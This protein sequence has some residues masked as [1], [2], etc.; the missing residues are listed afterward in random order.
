[1]TPEELLKCVA[2]VQAFYPR[3]VAG[4]VRPGMIDFTMGLSDLPV[5]CIDVA[6]GRVTYLGLDTIGS[7]LY[8]ASE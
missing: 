2:A 1:M 8:P 3:S 7:T 5:A 4:C 6:R